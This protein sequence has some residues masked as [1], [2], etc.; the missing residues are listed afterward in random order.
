MPKDLIL[1]GLRVFHSMGALWKTRSLSKHLYFVKSGNT[2]FVHSLSNGTDHQI[3]EGGG[4]VWA[5]FLC[6]NFFSSPKCLQEFFFCTIPLHDI[7]FKD[8]LKNFPRT[9]R[10]RGGPIFFARFFFNMFVAHDIFFLN[11]FC[12]R[13]FF[14]NLPPLPL[15]YL[16]VRP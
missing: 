1:T 5:I 2:E 6:T 3:F 7:F 16:M 4:G 8:D 10:R 9:A 15:K 13:I 11:F 14:W 12:E